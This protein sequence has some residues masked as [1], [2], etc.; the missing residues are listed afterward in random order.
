MDPISF[1]FILVSR[2]CFY[3]ENKINIFKV[4]LRV[5]IKRFFVG[6]YFKQLILQIFYMLMNTC[7]WNYPKCLKTS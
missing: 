6:L 5:Y 3:D 7:N 4:F 2:F 1:S